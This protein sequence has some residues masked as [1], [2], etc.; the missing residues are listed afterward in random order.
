MIVTAVISFDIIEIS[1]GTIKYRYMSY[2][3][4]D[5]KAYYKVETYAIKTL[6]LASLLVLL[7]HNKTHFSAKTIYLRYN[8]E[9]LLGNKAL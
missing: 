2:L 7:T 6:V 3:Y 4:A 1:E 8:N 9:S 5:N